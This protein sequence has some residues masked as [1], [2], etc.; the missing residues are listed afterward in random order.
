MLKR[1]H[2]SITACIVVILFS[3]SIN[4]RFININRLSKM[5]GVEKKSKKKSKISDHF[6]VEKPVKKK[7]TVNRFNGMSEEEV[8]L[9]GLPDYLKEGLDV[10]F[11]GIN[12]SMYAA[13]TGKYYDG[14]GNHFWQ[15]LFLSGFLPEPMGPKD[16]SKLL[17]LGNLIEIKQDV[18]TLSGG[19]L[20][21]HFYF[22]FIVL[23]FIMFYGPF[24]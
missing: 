5:V 20:S 14:P 13:Y 1:G 21:L 10:V 18:I 6:G 12:P 19:P 4:L 22:I 11:I 8:A 9:R 24:F 17:D 16:D 2:P 23:H 3:I 7:R 15:A